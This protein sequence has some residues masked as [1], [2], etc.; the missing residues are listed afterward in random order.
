MSAWCRL[1]AGR[2]EGW[3]WWW[4][5]AGVV[6]SEAGPVP[7]GW[8][9]E[10]SAISYDSY[11][12]EV[13]NATFQKHISSNGLSEKVYFPTLRVPTDPLQV[14][15]DSKISEHMGPLTDLTGTCRMLNPW[16]QTWLDIPEPTE[17]LIILIIGKAS[18][19]VYLAWVPCFSIQCSMISLNV[20]VFG[21]RQT[22]NSGWRC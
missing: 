17:H 14:I 12:E 3:W 5:G 8:G 20:R 11:G 2:E 21:P 15:T 22:I 13:R 1:Q 10:T 7:A 19:I 9:W 6:G 4:W 16:S 18:K